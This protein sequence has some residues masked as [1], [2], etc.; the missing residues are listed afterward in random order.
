MDKVLVDAVES[1]AGAAVAFN[2]DVHG[3]VR[4][5]IATVL[6]NTAA[7]NPPTS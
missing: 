5:C 7:E 3:A 4:A 1:A 2:A 6:A